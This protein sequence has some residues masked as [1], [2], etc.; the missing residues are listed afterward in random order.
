MSEAIRWLCEQQRSQLV[1]VDVQERLAAAMPAD[2]MADVEHN[3]GILLTAANQLN[4]PTLHSEQYP[5]GL[6]PTLPGLQQQLNEPV[7]K[8][9]FSCTAADDFA[10]R[11][12]PQ[13]PQVILCGIEA[14]ICVLQTAIGLMEQGYQVFVVE[15]GVCS[16]QDSNKR[17]VLARLRQAGVQVSNTESVL[18]EW[19]RDASHPEFRSLSKLIR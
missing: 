2:A 16:R 9:C 17:N 8:T 7:E 12:D 14:H 10:T 11:L 1:I 3:I 5:K 18:F 19:L 4:I 15:D 6:G 13:R